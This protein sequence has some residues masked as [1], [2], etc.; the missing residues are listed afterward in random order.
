M[1]AKCKRP[2]A[3]SGCI[4]LVSDTRYCERHAGNNASAVARRI[5]DYNRNRSDEERAMYNTSR[6]RN[7]RNWMLIR[8]PICQFISDITGKQC[9]EFATECHH[10]VSPRENE[11]LFCEASNIVCVCRAHHPKSVGHDGRSK[12]VA[13]VT[14]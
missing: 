11:D 8:N 14:D 9:T 2:C 5:Y 13:T 6:W 7:F 4:N 1:P 3:K 12:Y 10:L